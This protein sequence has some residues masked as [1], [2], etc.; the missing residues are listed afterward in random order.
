MALITW[1]KL[2]S[3]T[4]DSSGNGRNF[5]NNSVVFA[6]AK[7]S[8]GYYNDSGNYAR[9][10]FRFDSA[11][12][13][14]TN[15]TYA[16]WINSTGTT[17]GTHIFYQMAISNNRDCCGVI[18]YNIAVVNSSGNIVVGYGNTM[19]FTSVNAR[20][21][22]V[23]VAVSVGTSDIKIYFNGVLT[24]T[25]AYETFVYSGHPLTIGKMGFYYNGPDGFFA[26]KGFV[27]ELR[28]YNHALS[29]LEVK[30]LAH[31][32]VTHLKLNNNLTDAAGY[33]N[34]TGSISYT[35]DTKR[36]SHARA[37]GTVTIANGNQP[38]TGDQTIMMWLFPTNLSRRENPWNKAY[39]GEGTITQEPN[40]ALS[41]FWGTNGGN[42]TPYQGFGTNIGTVSLNTWT[43]IAFVRDITGGQLRFYRNGVLTNWD[44]TAYA[45]A[46][47]TTASTL[48]GAGY[49]NTYSGRISDV[50][51]YAT[52]LS[53]AD[54][55]EIYELGAI[56]DPSGN[57]FCHSTGTVSGADFKLTG[58]GVVQYVSIVQNAGL[59]GGV[60]ARVDSNGT[61]RIN[62]T[63][64]D[65]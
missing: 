5:T 61:L 40:G 14:Q 34:G 65:I 60:K 21:K 54:I 20:N 36:H 64:Q 13:L 47:K 43:H 30:R 1:L 57:L 38:V 22:W 8:Q 17:T 19:L 25:R 53:Q 9:R 51:Q 4:N 29:A 50:R 11:Y 33:I 44:P 24:Y 63:I 41:Y 42:S 27:D 26:W 3:D 37:S 16:A 10:A 39:G 46:A 2:D 12:N 55:Q 49:T 59:S 52:A 48:I 56:I 23:H 7:I 32:K 15:F 31:A 62:G 58:T 28:I 18:G 35:T 45:A 6:D